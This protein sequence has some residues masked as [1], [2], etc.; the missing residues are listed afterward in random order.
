M[1]F[2]LWLALA[3]TGCLVNLEAVEIDE[4]HILT[5][6]NHVLDNSII[7]VPRSEPKK[8]AGQFA[9]IDALFKF[10][11]RTNE[12]F[13]RNSASGNMDYNAY[14]DTLRYAFVEYKKANMVETTTEH[15]FVS[16][17]W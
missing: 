7:E 10:I 1:S 17:G 15:N 8:K 3:F 9:D 6:E 12:E 13:M 2:I 11:N 16:Y 4:N 14:L 5:P